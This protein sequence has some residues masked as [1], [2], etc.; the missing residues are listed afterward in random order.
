MDIPSCETQC[1]ERVDEPTGKCQ[2]R[3]VPIN[4]VGPASST[5][6]LFCFYAIQLAG[7]SSSHFN[8]VNEQLP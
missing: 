3:Q 5:G 8:I 7:E 1:M 4:D 6:Y 2:A